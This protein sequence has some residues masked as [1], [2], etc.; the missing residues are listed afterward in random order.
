MRDGESSVKK[1]GYFFYSRLTQ[2]KNQ[3]EQG[4]LVGLA[5]WAGNLAS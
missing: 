3:P 2:K 1:Y 5:R 4:V